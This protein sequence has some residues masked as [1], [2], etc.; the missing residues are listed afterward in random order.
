MSAPLERRSLRSANPRRWDIPILLLVSA[1]CLLAGQILPGVTLEFINREPDHYSVMGGV[2][3]LWRGGNPFL[4]AILFCFSIIF[5]TLKLVALALLWSVPMQARRRAQIGHWLKTLGKWSMLDTFV[6]TAL[7]GSVQ[8]SKIVTAAT[9]YAQPAVYFFAVAILLSILLTFLV[10][11]LADADGAG[12]HVI[13]RLGTSMVIAPWL[14]VACLVVTLFQPI[15]VVKKSLLRNDYTLP[16]SVGDLVEES[17][18]MLAA[19]M[20]IFV[21]V[22]PLV[23]FTGLGVVA[24]LQRSGRDVHRSLSRLVALERWAMVDVYVLGIWL[25][26]SKVALMATVDL[27]LGFWTVVGAAVLS[28]FCAIRVRRVY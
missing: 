11:R 14:A 10:A 27:P 2:L 6:V 23:Y 1:A 9:A 3:D 16:R 19:I 12:Q 28:V 20:V 5:P 22:L 15:L 25:V 24:L 7:I 17:E 8:L 4:A 26:Y 13:P 18:F 21:I